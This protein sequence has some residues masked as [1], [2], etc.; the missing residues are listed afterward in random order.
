[1]DEE[2][3]VKTTGLAGTWGYIAPE[4]ASS[5]KATKVRTYHLF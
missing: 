4:Y 2:A 5:G 3:G 1:M